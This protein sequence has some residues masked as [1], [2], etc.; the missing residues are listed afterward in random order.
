MANEVGK[1]TYK[2]VG[3]NS[4]FQSDINQSQS[5]ASKAAA[6]IGTMFKAAMV[7]AGTAIVSAATLGIKYNAQMEQYTVALTTALGDEGEAL[8]TIE[9]IKKDAA[10]TP[11]DVS[12][13]TQANQLLISTG[14]SAEESRKVILAL[15][16]AVSASGGGNDELSRMAANLQQIKNTGKATSMDVRQ[17]AMAGINIYGLIADYTGKTTE[18]VQKMDVSYELLT[19]SLKHASEE[20]GMY[21]DS[22]AQQ[23][24]TFNGQLSTLKDNASSFLGEVTKGLSDIAKDTALP[25]I[26]KY[27]EDLKEAFSDN[28]FSGLASKFGSVLGDL[29]AQIVGA[30]PEIADGAVL[31]I[32]SLVDGLTDNMPLIT[33]SAIEIINSL[34]FGFLDMLP[35][36]IDAGASLLVGLADGIIKALP[37][38]VAKAP[39]IISSIVDAILDNLP[40]IIDSGLALILALAE[41]LIDALPKL[42]EQVPKIVEKILTVITEH[43]PEILQQGVYIVYKLVDGILKAIP[44]ISMAAAQII[45]E[46]LSTLGKAFPQLVQAGAQIIQG[47]LQGIK[48]NIGRILQ[49]IWSLCKSLLKGVQNFFGIASPSKVFANIGKQ[50]DAGLAVGIKA[51]VEEPD[52]AMDDLSEDVM[53]AFSLKTVPS[54][55]YGS[56]SSGGIS[57]TSSTSVGDVNVYVDGATTDP[58]G[59]GSQ[60]VYELRQQSR[61]RGALI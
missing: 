46:I 26:N 9:Q 25:L 2:I 37:E 8:N 39:E 19:E 35:S 29:L 57:N 21:Y 41:G 34:L 24:K 61:Y 45:P 1:V 13:L 27:M 15:G 38:L 23:S 12:G 43:L 4:T 32:Q 53:S 31:I 51:N 49:E 50:L 5:I 28:G 48:N 33:S 20:G 14:E 36:L 17:F 59:L 60:I 55:I 52:I 16:D 10:V 40:A 11:F 6:K 22:M 56:A 30:V 44:K 47:L 54:R 3:D 7:A 18:E 42:A 58:K